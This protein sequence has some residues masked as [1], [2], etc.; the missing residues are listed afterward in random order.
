MKNPFMKKEDLKKC[1]YIIIRHG[2]SEANYKWQ[3]TEVA[4]GRDSQEFHQLFVDKNLVDPGLH[5]IGI[6]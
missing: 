3:K 1:S 5:D 4:H 2:Y 6:M